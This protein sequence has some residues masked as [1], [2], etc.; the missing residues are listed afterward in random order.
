MIKLTYGI[1]MYFNNFFVIFST[2]IKMS[3]DS[4]AKYYQIH[5]KWLQKK[6]VKDVKVF[7]KKKKIQK[8][9]RR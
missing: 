6:L 3:N 4:S 1:F 9:H 5:K 7:L 2:Y 8:S